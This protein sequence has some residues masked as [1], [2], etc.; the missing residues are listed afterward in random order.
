MVSF[1]VLVVISLAM[2]VLFFKVMAQFLLPMFL[3]VIL[4]VMFGPLHDWFVEKCKGHDR[5][6]AGL[7]TLTILLIVLLPITWIVY[8]AAR[9]GL[10]LAGDIDTGEITAKANAL[11]NRLQPWAAKVGFDLS[12]SIAPNDDQPSD[13][14]PSEDEAVRTPQPGEVDNRE[15]LLAPRTGRDKLLDDLQAKL[16]QLAAPAAL[17]GVQFLG[18]FL[19]G[20]GIMVVALYYFLADGPGMIEQFMRLSPLD[21]KYEYELL[22]EFVKISRAVVVATL[23][24]ALVQGI[25]AGFAYWLAGFELVFLL[26]ALTMLFAMVPFVGSAAIWVPCCLW[27]FLGE[28]RTTA[29]VVFLIYGAGVVSM[30]DNVIKP[31]V[32]SGT[33]NLHPLLALLSVL[34]GVTALGPIGILVG[35][36]L[37][38][39]L[40]AILNMLQTEINKFDGPQAALAGAGLAS[41]AAALPEA[42][43]S[44]ESAD[45]SEN[46]EP[47]VAQPSQPAA[48]KPD[49]AE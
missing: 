21:D 32:L 4:V 29:G 19:L 36:M 1:A 5:V 14:Q 33:S 49:D 26:I 12:D 8:S 7:T 17:G 2:L 45:S 47:H 48:D 35:P 18:K 3:A 28:E 31:L 11:A 22:S 34:G 25:L 41:P 42:E 9:E 37:V 46:G 6:A 38:S 23:L 16:Q 24:S 39:F 20:L 10:E 44:A 30:A 13:D 40:Q 43:N 27:L 15:P